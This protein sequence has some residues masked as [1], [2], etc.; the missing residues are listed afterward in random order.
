MS[1]SA[2]QVYPID[3]SD[4][5]LSDQSAYLSDGQECEASASES[6]H[7]GNYALTWPQQSVPPACP[8]LLGEPPR[9]P[10][11]GGARHLSLR[12]RLVLAGAAVAIAFVF[13]TVMVAFAH[14]CS[15]RLR[16]L[17]CVL[18]GCF[19]C[20]TWL[21]GWQ[22]GSGPLGTLSAAPTFSREC[23]TSSCWEGQARSGDASCG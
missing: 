18:Y 7:Q 17:A 4:A 2:C 21:A 16:H 3:F 23:Q 10:R 13:A 1:Y 9:P 11:G 15:W 14:D 12:Q 22:A 19:R 8:P 20:S 6:H 5:S